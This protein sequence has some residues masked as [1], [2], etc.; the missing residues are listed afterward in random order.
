MAWYR[1]PYF[2]LS[3]VLLLA[4]LSY[5]LAANLLGAIV[6]QT[7]TTVMLFSALY[8]VTSSGK[9][10]KAMAVLIVPVLAIN[11]F[12][13]PSSHSYWTSFSLVVSMAFFT[14]TLSAILA[15]IVTAEEVSPDVIFGSIAAYLL[16]GVVLAMCYHMVNVLDPG[17]S[18]STIT[19]ALT[20]DL[21]HDHF[22]DFLYF[23][24]VT[25]TSVGYGDIT[26]VGSAARSLAMFEGILGQ[27]Y[28][29]ILIARL[30]SIHIAQK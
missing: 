3:C 5:P 10:F 21:R 29:A 28:V 7:V 24:F 25:L 27:L 13:D 1:G 19:G 26:P 30:V 2:I 22:S 17:N 9:L 15:Q 20:A 14:I 16:F 8:A 18:I 4:V 23:S 6:L 11:W 12:V